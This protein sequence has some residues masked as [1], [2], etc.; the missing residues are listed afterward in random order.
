MTSEINEIVELRDQGW[1][2]QQIGNQLGLSRGT[3]HAALA[4]IGQATSRGEIDAKILLAYLETTW[5]YHKIES[6]DNSLQRTLYRWRHGETPA[7]KLS[8]VDKLLLDLGLH[9]QFFLNWCEDEG[10]NPWT[11][12]DPGGN[13]RDNG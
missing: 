8:Y 12:L 6:S 3:V 1:T 7:A 2:L 10:L 11:N 9:L 4:K 13:Q 5:Q